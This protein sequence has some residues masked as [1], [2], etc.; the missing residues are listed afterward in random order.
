MVPE[1]RSSS[2]ALALALL[3]LALAP[4]AAARSTPLPGDPRFLA[5]RDGWPQEMS[6]TYVFAGADLGLDAGGLDGVKGD[7]FCWRAGG[8]GRVGA[9]DECWRHREEGESVA[10]PLSFA[11]EIVLGAVVMGRPYCILMIDDSGAHYPCC[12]FYEPRGSWD[13]RN[14]LPCVTP[15]PAVLA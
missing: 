15:E 4:D 11:G 13:P 8:D 7:A 14:G 3:L 9:S 2:L 10:S 1:A 5:L 12:A 6:G